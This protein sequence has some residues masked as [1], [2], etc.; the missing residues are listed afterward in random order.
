MENPN[1]DV[2]NDRSMNLLAST[3]VKRYNST[4]KK[5]GGKKPDRYI[6]RL[7]SQKAYKASKSIK[8]LDLNN[9]EVLERSSSPARL[10]SP[11]FFHDLRNTGHYQAVRMSTPNTTVPSSTEVGNSSSNK[12]VKNNPEEKRYRE[13]IADSLGFLSPDRVYVF[14][15]NSDDQSL[16]SNELPSN[17]SPLFYNPLKVDTLIT[18]LPQNKGMSYLATSS[19][20]M[21]KSQSSFDSFSTPR[22]T[23][24]I[25]SHIPYRVL[26]APCLRNDFYSNL[27]SW[28]KTTNNVI[29]GL[30]CSVYIWSDS[31]GAIPIIEHEYLHR[32]HDLVTCVSFCPKNSLFIVGTKKGRLLLFDQETCIENFRKMASPDKPLFEYQSPT[33][34]GISCIEWYL[35]SYETK[36]II[37]EESGDV[38]ILKIAK[39]L[40]H[41]ETGASSFFV[42][43]NSPNSIINFDNSNES[44]TYQKKKDPLWKLDYVNKFQ[45]QTQQVCGT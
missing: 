36:F 39:F 17:S 43:S 34:R 21:A 29:V 14:T 6:P 28:S 38:T 3:S 22:P 31:Q 44:R 32:L 4:R 23:K 27:V 7:T 19:S 30:G 5:L 16:N 9:I 8:S 41:N 2:S 20:R 40:K 10:S 26:D 12:M 42:D 24:R 1:T 37:G 11:E 18:T 33:M 25:K 13:F 45:A 15:N 35:D